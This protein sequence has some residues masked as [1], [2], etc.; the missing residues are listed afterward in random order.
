MKRTKYTYSV[1]KCMLI[2]YF[3]VICLFLFWEQRLQNNP[4]KRIWVLTAYNVLT[5]KRFKNDAYDTFRN[6]TV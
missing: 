5:N 1:Y 6:L 2:S 4:T 3:N